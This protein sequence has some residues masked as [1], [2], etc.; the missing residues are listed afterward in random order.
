MS[1]SDLTIFERLAV[2]ME[3]LVP[4]VRDLQRLLGEGVVNEALTRRIEEQRASARENA[5][6]TEDLSILAA[7]TAAYAAGDALD[8]EV[9]EASS[10][11]FD[12]NVHRCAYAEMMERLGARDIGHLLICNQDY[13]MADAMGLEL[14]RTQT[15]MQGGAFCDFRYRRRSD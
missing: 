13:A 4:L 11:R 15:C 2:Q 8:Y 10:D 7:G 5:T 6:R 3:A 9:L 14:T 12:M 1:S